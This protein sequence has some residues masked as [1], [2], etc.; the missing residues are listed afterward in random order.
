MRLRAERRGVSSDARQP[1]YCVSV[2]RPSWS[3][4]VADLGPE[5]GPLGR[6]ALSLAQLLDREVACS[7]GGLGLLAATRRS[8]ARG[9][10]LVL[11]SAAM[12]VPFCP[13]LSNPSDRLV[14][15]PD[16][17][18]GHGSR[19][20]SWTVESRDGSVGGRPGCTP[21]CCYPIMA[22]SWVEVK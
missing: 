7:S 20:R 17:Q 14:V 18:V 5:R 3:K 2:V 13:C 16:R 11:R 4:R 15:S 9:R 1:A 21:Y 12:A 10:G 8:T 22:R 6:P 19:N